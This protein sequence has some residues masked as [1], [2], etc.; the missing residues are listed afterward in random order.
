MA[1]AKEE[2]KH[3]HPPERKKLKV[4]KGGNRISVLT[5]NPEVIPLGA[6]DSMVGELLPGDHG[7]LPIGPDGVPTGPATLDPPTDPAVQVCSVFA[8]SPT[9]SGADILV[10]GSGAPLVAPLIPNVDPRNLPPVE[11]PIAHSAKADASKKA[12]ATR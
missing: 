9:A 5:D 8:N 2:V 10:S 4:T 11:P 1:N 6:Y 12:D 3:P 7:W